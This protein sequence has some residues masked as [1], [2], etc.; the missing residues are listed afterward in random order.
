MT[1][2]I[3]ILTILVVGLIYYNKT[4]PI[5]NSHKLPQKVELIEFTN[6]EKKPEYD[7][8]V[9]GHKL[10]LTR[11]LGKNGYHFFL[12]LNTNGQNQENLKKI[13]ISWSEW[14]QRIFNFEYKCS[15][16]NVEIN[17]DIIRIDI[18]SFN[19]CPGTK[20]ILERTSLS[21][22]MTIDLLNYL[23]E[24]NDFEWEKNSAGQSKFF[25]F[26]SKAEL[27][28]FKKGLHYLDS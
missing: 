16:P 1:T 25:P 22:V 20:N 13:V 18:G 5:K 10:S 9:K 23:P 19:N 15:D 21:N 6:P 8:Y 14:S 27:L 7:V 2:I 26:L 12:T 28:K 17:K 11:E 3:I 24:H 4:K